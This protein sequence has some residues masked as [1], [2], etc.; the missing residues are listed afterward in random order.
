MTHSLAQLTSAINSLAA[1]GG[2]A[3]HAGISTAQAELQGP[4]QDPDHSKAMILLTDGQSNASQALAA[5]NAAKQ[6]GTVI[7]TIGL[8]ADA[9]ANLLRQI[10]TTPDHYYYAPTPADLEDI[11]LAIAGQVG[12]TP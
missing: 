1:G 3:I 5:A 9:D 10:A 4:R 11:Y 2:T 7:F 6:A 8:G 12:C